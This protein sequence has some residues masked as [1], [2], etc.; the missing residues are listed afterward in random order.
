MIKKKETM[1]E[2]QIDSKNSMIKNDNLEPWHLNCLFREMNIY[3]T[4]KLPLNLFCVAISQL[5]MEKSMS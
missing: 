2:K 3:R 1:G 4:T 5:T